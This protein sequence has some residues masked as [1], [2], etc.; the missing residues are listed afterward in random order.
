MP[1]P[2][3]LDPASTTPLDPAV[4]AAM[5]EVLQGPLGLGNPASATHPYGQDAAA[6]V[7]RGATDM[8]DEVSVDFE[9][10]G[11]EDGMED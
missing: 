2:T 7:E 6:A 1:R 8:D 4:T 3:F 10:V 11:S 9:D 5:L